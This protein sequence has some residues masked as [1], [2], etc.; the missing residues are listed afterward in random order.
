M[1]AVTASAST[2]TGF[3][4]KHQSVDL[5]GRRSQQVSM[6]LS[7]LEGM[8]S[9]RVSVPASRHGLETICGASCET[10]AQ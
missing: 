1:S 9:H 8:R 5:I 2:S 7:D 3:A 6:S 4:R 10:G